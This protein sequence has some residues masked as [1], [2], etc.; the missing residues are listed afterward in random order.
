M[1][2]RLFIF[3]ITLILLNACKPYKQTKQI[4]QSRVNV[5]EKAPH[6]FSTPPQSGKKDD[7]RRFLVETSN[8][9]KLIRNS[10]TPIDATSHIFQ[11]FTYWSP[12]GHTNEELIEAI[13][14]PTLKKDNYLEYD[15]EGE[16]ASFLFRFWTKD[17]H[18]IKMEPSLSEIR[19]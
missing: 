12:I 16:N 18:I 4:E 9:I 19:Q 5:K 2:A 13:G 14:E 3:A 11:L 15:L 7:E 8:S 6:G 17:D 10:K 1:V